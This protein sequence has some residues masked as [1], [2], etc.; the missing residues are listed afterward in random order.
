MQGFIE[1]LDGGAPATP[2]Q[3]LVRTVL[4]DGEAPT[5]VE[6]TLPRSVHWDVVTVLTD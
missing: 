2:G 6:V 4:Y 5:I 1:R 3:P